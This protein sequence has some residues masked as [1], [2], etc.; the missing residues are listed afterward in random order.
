MRAFIAKAQEFEPVI[1][2]DLHNYIVAK[3]VE[4]RKIQRDGSDEQSYMY[5]TPRT[6]L[7]IIRLAQA[8]AKLSF[9][10][11]VNQNDVDEAI[12]LMDFSI[13]SLR[14]IKAETA[15]EKK[16]LGKFSSSNI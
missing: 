13:R 4:K 11:E 6:L 2:S 14:S 15:Q 7:A 1:P 12:K 9:R 10:E 16:K 3:Y 5:V 8:M